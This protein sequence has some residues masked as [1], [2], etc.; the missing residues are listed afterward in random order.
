MIRLI[1][2]QNHEWEGYVSESTWSFIGVSWVN[3]CVVK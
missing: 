2:E 3:V 1:N